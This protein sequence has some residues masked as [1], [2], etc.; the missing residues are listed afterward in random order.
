MR[1]G[2]QERSRICV[3]VPGSGPREVLP[4][5]VGL[6]ML[7]L[8]AAVAITKGFLRS[9][10]PPDSKHLPCPRDPGMGLPGLHS[11]NS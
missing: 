1:Q 5:R 6:F 2:R 4:W 10:Q 7:V 11:S 8:A 9:L 3:L